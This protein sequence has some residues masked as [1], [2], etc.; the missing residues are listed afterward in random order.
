MVATAPQGTLLVE[1]ADPGLKH[2]G[3]GGGFTIADS[4]I[5]LRL[6]CLIH[7][8]WGAADNCSRARTPQL[9]QASLEVISRLAND[10]AIQFKNGPGG[11]GVGE[12]C[13]CTCDDCIPSID[14]AAQALLSLSRAPAR[15]TPGLED[16]S[17]DASGVEAPEV[18]LGLPPMVG[19]LATELAVAASSAARG[20]V[21]IDHLVRSPPAAPADAS[22]GPGDA[23]AAARVGERVP[24]SLVTSSSSS[25]SGES[26]AA[27]MD[28]VVHQAT[29]AG[30]RRRGCA[31]CS[32]TGILYLVGGMGLCQK[33]LDDM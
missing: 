1:A 7:E 21:A 9:L 27:E 17:P 18:L 3:K 32:L 4:E 30:R 31:R 5:P 20:Q 10:W 15:V 13:E 19:A 16:A 23:S 25:D 11:A 26:P 6:A 12:R 33:C 8:S 28:L 14:V 2:N 24:T 22:F 29:R